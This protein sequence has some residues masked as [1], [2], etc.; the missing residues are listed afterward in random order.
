MGLCPACLLEAD[1]PAALLGDSIE[2]L[3]AIARG[4]MGT[5]WK[6]RHLAL[7]RTVAVKFL[8]PELAAHHDFE[9]RLERE[10][11]ALAMLSHPGIVAV[12]DFGRQDG[13]GYI[14]MEYVEGRALSAMIPLPAEQA[15]GITRQ[16]LDALAYAH[17]R[18]VV[19]RDVKPE[20]VLVD[21]GGR[22]K[23]TDFGIARIVGGEPE[24]GITARGVLIGTPR[25]LAPEA[26]AG[27][28][29]DPRMDVFAVGVMLREMVEGV[30]SKAPSRL[31]AS[32]AKIVARAVDPDPDRRYAGAA[33]MALALE[34][35][36]VLDAAGEDLLPEERNWMRVVALVQT[37]ATAVA[38]WAFVQSVT[39]KII[40]PG[41]IQPLIMLRPERLADGRVLSRARFETWP[42]L[43]AIAA[44][45]AAVAA[46]GALRR[47]WRDARLEHARPDQPVRES[48]AV[49][50][51]GIVAVVVYATRTVLDD[52]RSLL[53]AYVPIIGGV[54]EIVALSFFW[55]AILQAWRASR[56][57]HREWPLWLGVL[58]ALIPPV[59]DL[60]AFIDAR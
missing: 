25:Y 59:H 2:L 35:V 32:L 22:V 57:L 27:A 40:A 50:A 43:A 19:H 33:D 17:R 16:V 10:A 41:D 21:E 44:I 3:E 12:H 51:C 15:V 8:A 11:R 34:E 5:V 18:G 31:P 48:R 30:V 20:N 56:P 24:P 49:L 6:A 53:F 54:I 46:H 26:L 52:G 4:G 38:L 1:L 7:G 58:L 9:R 60:A 55:M 14:V 29:P 28:P 37:L 47:H 13:F 42:S 45:A 23:V 39:P 36:G